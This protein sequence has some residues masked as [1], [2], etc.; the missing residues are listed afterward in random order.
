MLEK[1]KILKR[2]NLRPAELSDSATDL[3]LPENSDA[4]TAVAI[5]P[6][7]L[8]DLTKKIE[9]I[10]SEDQALCRADQL[11]ATGAMTHFE[12]GGILGRIKAEKWLGEYETF[13]DLC[14][15]RFGMSER[16]ARYLINIY[17]WVTEAHLTGAQI[18]TIDWTKMR[19]LPGEI[20]P[21]DAEAWIDKARGLTVLELKKEIALQKHAA[22]PMDKKNLVSD[23]SEI[24]QQGRSERMA[25]A[26]A[27]ANKTKG[28]ASANNSQRR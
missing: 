5:P 25:P 23:S 8:A 1:F 13:S 15:V 14:E 16:K 11:R 19:L 9:S 3:V 17:N 7:Y 24:P 26:L 20:D 27:C 2:I 21:S 22:S 18:A 6:E 4:I 28:K 10:S 12:L